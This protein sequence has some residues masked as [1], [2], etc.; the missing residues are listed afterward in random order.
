[1]EEKWKTT[2]VHIYKL[3]LFILCRV[4]T[5]V[6]TERCGAVK[7]CTSTQVCPL[8]PGCVRAVPAQLLQL[9]QHQRKGGGP[10]RVNKGRKGL[11]EEGAEGGRG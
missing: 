10:V 3:Q 9:G 6:N 7:H 1:M 4:C 11:R 5:G 8:Q 2:N